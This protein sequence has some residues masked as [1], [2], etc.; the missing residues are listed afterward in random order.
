MLFC[1]PSRV[2]GQ[3]T[4]RGEGEQEKCEDCHAGPISKNY[5]VQ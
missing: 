1:G 5:M 4:T 3:H 2:A